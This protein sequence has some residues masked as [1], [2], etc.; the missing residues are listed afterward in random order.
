M[1]FSS[2]ICFLFLL[3][4][5]INTRTEKMSRN[6][7]FMCSTD[8]EISMQGKYRILQIIHAGIFRSNAKIPFRRNSTYTRLNPNTFE[9]GLITWGELEE[10][11]LRRKVMGLFH[12]ECL[13]GLPLSSLCLFF[14][15]F[16]AKMT[17]SV[18]L[19]VNTSLFAD[20]APASY[21]ICSSNTYCLQIQ[22]LLY[23]FAI[24]HTGT[25][26]AYLFL[27]CAHST[28]HHG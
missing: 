14:V 9:S 2:W 26:M 3:E 8:T 25:R 19:C 1:R 24:F 16:Y 13:S 18:D 12:E 20:C 15:A 11:F 5:S 7:D 22:L 10:S 27:F 4:V 23:Y 17:H 21:S 6:L 28:H